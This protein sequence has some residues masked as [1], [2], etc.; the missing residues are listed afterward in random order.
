MN[1][2]LAGRRFTLHQDTTTIGRITGNDVVI[3]ELSVSRNHAV[4]RFVDD[5]WVLEDRESH[6]GTFVNGTK[7]DLPQALKDGDQLQF[8]DAVVEY[9]VIS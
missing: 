5:H 4:L 7:I 9:H 2:P 1:G 3:A 6:N 8:G